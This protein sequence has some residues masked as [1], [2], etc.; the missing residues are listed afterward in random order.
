MAHLFVELGPLLLLDEQGLLPAAQELVVGAVPVVEPPP[1]QLHHPG[2]QMAGKG[3]VVGY[4]NHGPL[5]GQQEFLQPDNGVDVQ[6]VGGLVQ[7]QQRGALGQ[8]PGQKHPALEAAREGF[9]PGARRQPQTGQHSAQPV[10]RGPYLLVIALLGVVDTPLPPAQASQHASLVAQALGRHLV[11]LALQAVI[12]LLGQVA[13][14]QP[15]FAAGL[16]GVGGQGA[17]QHLEQTGLAGPVAPHEANPLTGLHP[18]TNSVQE[19]GTAESQA[20]VK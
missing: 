2:G 10:V 15:H 6:V 14:F 19:L 3:A 9:H 13:G 4:E 8:G 16:P 7:E 17:G 1:V 11:D 12:H 20:D 18:E 5:V